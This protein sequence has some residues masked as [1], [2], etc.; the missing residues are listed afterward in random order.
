[1]GDN[2]K[3]A[4]PR[5][6]LTAFLIDF[7]IISMILLP[8]VSHW[9]DILIEHENIAL[10]VTTFIFIFVFTIRDILIGGTSVG[11]RIFHLT[12]RYSF[13]PQ[14][15]PS[16]YKLFLRNIFFF[17]WPLEAIV[18]FFQNRFSLNSL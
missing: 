11:K 14:L 3:A 18:F 5:K 7:F 4:D 17:I 12:I 2:L 13:N 9:I 8:I 16:L 10:S 1:M 15:K 6:R